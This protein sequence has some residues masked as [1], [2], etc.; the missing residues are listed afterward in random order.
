M[1]AVP[2]KLQW[3]ALRQLSVSAWT[4]VL[5]ATGVIGIALRVWAYTSVIGIADGDEGVVGLTARHILDGQFPTFIWGLKYGGIQ[6]CLLAAPLFWIFGS[7]W[8]LLRL[9]P[10][11]LWA[12]AAF[13]I[14]RVGKRT[15]GE[16]G[17]TVAAA[18]YWVWPPYLFYQLEHEHGYYGS[19]VFYCALFLLLALRVVEQPSTRRVGL[20]GLALG[21]GFW[22]SSQLAPVML[23]VIVWTVWRQPKSL[24]KLWVALPLAVLGAL[25]WL[26]WNA[27]H[28][29][30]SLSLSYPAH[31]TYLHRLR[32]FYSPLLPMTMGIR[33][34]WTQ[35]RILPAP[36]T[37]LVLLLLFGLFVYG[38]I[39]TRKRDVSLIYFVAF[40]FPFVYAISEWT[41][42]SSDP[43]YLVVFTP[44]LPLLLSQLATTRLRGSLLIALGVATTV[45]VLHHAMVLQAAPPKDP[46]RNF[47]P[48]I[49]AL[50][51]LDVHYVYS[52]H[53][54]VYRLAFET[55]ERVIGAKNEWGPLHWNGT[56][57]MVTPD[58][59][60]RYPP[61]ERTVRDHRHA[62]VFYRDQLPPVVKQLKQFGYR[63]VNVGSLVVYLLPTH[64]AGAG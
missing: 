57:A 12:G 26:L 59:Y 51:R 47:G 28:G 9:V 17:A 38:A 11:A 64:G 63:H 24:R 1:A 32:I 62:F 55:R 33:Q 20:F 25:P 60:I 29:W 13:L 44:L 27:T 7:S 54:V 49:A 40:V 48:L 21:L 34:Y 10:M 39:R 43:R 18:L 53:W 16:P 37:Y 6:E 41:I 3:Q 36:L 58:S 35:S 30:A 50:D 31:S 56:Q 8:F 61:W 46:P 23:P 19:D 5:V 22:Q 15:I 14:W 4:V 52:T 2:A 45:V 42:E